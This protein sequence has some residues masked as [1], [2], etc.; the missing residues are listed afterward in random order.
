MS[1]AHI[2][3]LVMLLEKK[4]SLN[5]LRFIP[6]W[7]MNVSKEMSWLSI[8]YLLR[9]FSHGPKWWTDQ[10]VHTAIQ[11]A[12]RLAWLKIKYSSCEADSETLS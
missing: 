9:Y 11:K 7:N 1:L 5:S 3:D 2:D 12:T 8:Q 10:Q 4:R 6:P